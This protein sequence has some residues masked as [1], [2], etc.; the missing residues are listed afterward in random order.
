[1]ELNWRGM[2]RLAPEG[3]ARPVAKTWN[4]CS[5]GT[6][7]SDSEVGKEGD[8]GNRENLVLSVSVP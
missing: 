6:Q 3:Q 7:N 5:S 8:V 2:D 1:M 4:H